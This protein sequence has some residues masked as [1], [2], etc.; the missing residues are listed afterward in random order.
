MHPK[1]PSSL[2]SFK[3][4]WVLPFWYWLTQVVLEKRPLNECSNGSSS[5]PV[6]DSFVAHVELQH[7]QTEITNV[8]YKP[9]PGPKWC[10]IVTV[11]EL[12]SD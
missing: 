3:S 8:N 10:Q 2:A 9:Q 11:K 7:S 1:T 5:H 12:L 6:A 4:R